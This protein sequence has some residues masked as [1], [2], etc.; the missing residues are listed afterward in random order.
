M[1]EIGCIIPAHGLIVQRL[2]RVE[3]SRCT[4]AKLFT[5]NRTD[6]DRY[7]VCAHGVLYNTGWI[8]PIPMNDFAA[9]TAQNYTAPEGYAYPPPPP[10]PQEGY[11]YPSPPPPAAYYPYP[12]QVYFGLAR[13][14]YV[15][16]YWRGYGP[17]YAYGYGR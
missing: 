8:A 3:Q 13:P 14:Y 11:A 15:G 1:G 6:Q 7:G 5:S 17:R 2:G 12:E 16:P 4:A 10:L 9:A